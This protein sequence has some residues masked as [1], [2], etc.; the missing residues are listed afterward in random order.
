VVRSRVCS[1]RLKYSLI[2]HIVRIS[3]NE[4][5]FD[6]AGSFRIINSSLFVKSSFYEHFGQAT[7]VGHIRDREQHS[8]ARK[9]LSPGFSI[10][11]L[12]SQ[13]SVIHELVDQ[14]I[15]QL[16]RHSEKNG[17]GI[18]MGEAFTWLT[19]DIVG[20]LA[21][22]DSF[23]AVKD[24]KSSFWL[25]LILDPKW[26][27]VFLADGLRARSSFVSLLLPFMLP[28]NAGKM[29]AQHTAL[30]KQKVLQRMTADT[31]SREDFFANILRSG[32][33]SLEY[34]VAEG[35]FLTVA[36]GETT[37]TIM[38]AVLYYLHANPGY[39]ERLT[40]EIRGS[41]SSYG[42][43]TGTS[44]SSLPFLQAIIEETLRMYPPVAMSLPRVSPG[45]VIEGKYIPRGVVVGTHLFSASRN[46]A[47]Y[48]LPEQFRPERWLGEPSLQCKNGPP[49]VLAFSGGTYQCL[50][51][52]MAYLEMRI[53][54]AKLLFSFDI[55]VVNDPGDLLK[56]S[57]YYVLW[58]KPDIKVK[59]NPVS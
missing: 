6:S 17:A 8:I 10:S 45:A 43:I 12:R 24:W 26:L 56:D 11:A 20:E 54:L 23:D 25:S 28:K 58:V 42:E 31:H 36:G 9:R 29:F 59:F 19:F 32:D 57:M 2:G 51:I 41:F 16:R 33:F 47:T 4:L 18:S 50:G 44:T 5:S 30:T 34:L 35:R 49:P 22:G 15:N 14:F 40:E 46:A 52:T 39:R 21:F 55:E 27:F 7:P 13:E 38:T 53:T 3:P 48:A 37:A 1:S